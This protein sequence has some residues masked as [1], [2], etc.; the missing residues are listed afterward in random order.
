MATPDRESGAPPV[1][2]RGGPECG[3]PHG[4]GLREGDAEEVGG[5]MDGHGI[6]C[7]GDEVPERTG[8]GGG[9][10]RDLT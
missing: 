8:E 3:T 2:L 7:G 5:H 9:G 10:E 1:R 4:G 6:L